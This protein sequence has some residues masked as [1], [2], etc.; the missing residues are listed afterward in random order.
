MTAR[1]SSQGGLYSGRRVVR[2]RSGSSASL[3]KSLPKTSSD[4]L[5]IQCKSSITMIT[6]ERL[7]RASRSCCKSS[8][9][10]RPI[11]TPSNPFSASSGT[12]RPSMWSNMAKFRAECRPSVVSPA[13]SFCATS[14]SASPALS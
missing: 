8:R 4:T 3:S 5:S 6:G 10:R 13:S 11:S 14:F 2:S 9:V 12:L 7:Q 1:R